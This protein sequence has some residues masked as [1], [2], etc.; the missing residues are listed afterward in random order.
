MAGA[1]YRNVK[2]ARFTATAIARP[3]IIRIVIGNEGSRYPNWHGTAVGG[4][5]NANVSFGCWLDLLPHGDAQRCLRT[6]DSLRARLPL[7]I[8]VAPLSSPTVG[9]QTRP[10]QVRDPL[11]ADAPSLKAAGLAAHDVLQRWPVCNRLSSQRSY[12][13]GGAWYTLA[14]CH[15]LFG[16]LL[17]HLRVFGK[18]RRS[19]AAQDVRRLGELNILVTNDLDAISPRVAE[20]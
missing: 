8:H 14:G 1:P 10:A 3:S 16:K 9:M 20:V 7:A 5:S 6:D 17:C 4:V 13:R 19:H 15:A 12:R 11:C 18:V 2:P